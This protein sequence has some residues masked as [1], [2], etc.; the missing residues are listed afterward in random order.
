MQFIYSYRAFAILT[1]LASIVDKNNY[2][3]RQELADDNKACELLFNLVDYFNVDPNDLFSF[4]K[5]FK[6]TILYNADDFVMHWSNEFPKIMGS[7]IPGE[8]SLRHYRDCMDELRWFMID[9]HKLFDSIK[10]YINGSRSERRIIMDFG[11][12][13]TKL[14]EELLDRGIVYHVTCVEKTE[15]AVELTKTCKHVGINIIGIEPS[16]DLRVN[17][18]VF[19]LIIISQ[20][21]HSKTNEEIKRIMDNLI[22]LLRVGGSILIIG[23][24]SNKNFQPFFNEHM[25]IRTGVDPDEAMNYVRH[26][27]PD[28]TMQ[29]SMLFVDKY[30]YCI[31]IEKIGGQTWLI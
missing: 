1:V 17:S 26:E 3:T 27:Y 8:E 19:D 7:T 25:K 31:R 10:A 4:I 18:P 24:K 13:S 9:K 22:N 20:V 14:A 15:V 30:S 21:L 2:K 16:D 12:G 23:P 5:Q 29:Q 6:S 11:C 28:N